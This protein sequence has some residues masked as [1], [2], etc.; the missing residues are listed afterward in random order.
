MEGCGRGGGLSCE[1]FR[2]GWVAVRN[3]KVD[4]R[5]CRAWPVAIGFNRS[6][7]RFIYMAWR[8]D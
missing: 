2:R 3:G 8:H 7:L 4:A 6:G 1:E 5:D